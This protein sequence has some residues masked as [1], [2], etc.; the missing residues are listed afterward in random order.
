MV[1][2][3]LQRGRVVLVDA[4]REYPFPNGISRTESIE[5]GVH[6]YMIIALAQGIL[7]CCMVH[8]CVYICRIYLCNSHPLFCC[9]QQEVDSHVLVMQ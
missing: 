4:G 3:I 8:G 9:S 7:S 2:R 5:V 6:M 1:L